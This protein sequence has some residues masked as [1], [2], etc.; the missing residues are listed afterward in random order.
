MAAAI[1]VLNE[2]IFNNLVSSDKDVPLTVLNVVGR[3][4]V[5]DATYAD[6]WG[7][8]FTVKFNPEKCDDCVSCI[9]EI[10][11]PTKAF[12]KKKGIDHARCYNCGLCAVT[13]TCRP[14]A[15]DVDLKTVTVDGKKV[16]VVLRQSDRAGAIKLA[17]D[18]KQAIL[19]G[20][21]PIVAPTDKLVFSQ[22]VK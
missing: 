8:N 17:T 10:H 5:A 4:K 13:C 3:E 9:A 1:P 15:F 21:F 6:V 16:P 11:C 7:G 2:E 12:R 14:D 22:E 18:L 19:K 20:A